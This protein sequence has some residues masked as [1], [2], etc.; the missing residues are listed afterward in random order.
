MQRSPLLASVDGVFISH[1]P[2]P[3]T[4]SA[5]PKSPWA[6][7]PEYFCM[8]CLVGLIRV[9]TAL[10]G[11]VVCLHIPRLD[12]CSSP[13]N[14]HLQTALLQVLVCLARFAGWILYSDL[15]SISWTL[16]AGRMAWGPESSTY[17]ACRYEPTA[18]LPRFVPI[19]RWNSAKAVPPE[20]ITLITHL[21]VE[22]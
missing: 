17:Q 20:S 4:T 13:L 16:G 7:S 18:A 15:E 22:K 2:K 5:T 12:H 8:R 19:Q 21:S 9:V 14:S 11:V 10:S 3:C 6:T 1:S